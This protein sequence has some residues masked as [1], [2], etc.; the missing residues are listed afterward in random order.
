MCS[1]HKKINQLKAKIANNQ[2][3][4]ST[5]TNDI[6]IDLTILPLHLKSLCN[7]FAGFKTCS[8]SQIA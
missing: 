2:S 3:S 5:D 8:T 1:E 4:K 7:D 6:N